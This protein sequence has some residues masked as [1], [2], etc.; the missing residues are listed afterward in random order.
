MNERETSLPPK[1]DLGS[2]MKKWKITFIYDRSA[3]INVEII[4]EFPHPPSPQ[5]WRTIEIEEEIYWQLDYGDNI[6]IIRQRFL[7]S[8]LVEQV[9]E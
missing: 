8:I 4:V 9:I 7:A 3:E 5:Y 1:G 2:S 6:Y